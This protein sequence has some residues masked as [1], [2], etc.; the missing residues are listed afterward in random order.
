MV[1]MFAYSYT[2]YAVVRMTELRKRMYADTRVMAFIL[3]R[4]SRRV[5][6][7]IRNSGL[8]T[9]P[10]RWIYLNV[11]L[12]PAYTQRSRIITQWQFSI[13]VSRSAELQKAEKGQRKSRRGR[14][15]RCRWA[16]VAEK[17]RPTCAKWSA[18][19]A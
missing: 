14:S 6:A 7:D 5:Y 2:P 8:R 9:I 15:L 1:Q 11:A 18:Y 17:T 4:R 10:R 13:H 19:M 16:L 12:K 3:L